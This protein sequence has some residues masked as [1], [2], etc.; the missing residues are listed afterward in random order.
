VEDACG[1]SM[2]LPNHHEWVRAAANQLRYPSS[3]L[4][5]AMCSEWSKSVSFDEVSG[6]VEHIQ[7]VVA[8]HAK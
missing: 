5:Q 3:S 8:S 2:T 1:K 7:D 4:W 6:L